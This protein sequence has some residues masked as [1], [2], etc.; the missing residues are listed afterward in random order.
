MNIQE[1]N[2]L[3]ENLKEGDILTFRNAMPKVRGHFLLCKITNTG[4]EAGIV[5]LPIEK[6]S[7]SFIVV[8]AADRQPWADKVIKLFDVASF[9]E[10]LITD[11]LLIYHD[12]SSSHILTINGKDLA[13]ETSCLEH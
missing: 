12:H 4:S 9:E 3:M 7:R 10:Y 13:K 2:W 5:I 11:R 6:D 8:D 1:F